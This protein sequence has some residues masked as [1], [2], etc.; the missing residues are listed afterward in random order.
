MAAHRMA[1]TFR[2]LEVPGA[3]VLMA[4]TVTVVAITLRCLPRR[5]LVSLRREM[6]EGLVAQVV[7]Q[8]EVP[9]AR[10]VALGEIRWRRG[11]SSRL[12]QCS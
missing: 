1:Q 9:V 7:V 10:A 4:V 8:E 6:V 3:A 2:D 11:D 5:R 12:T